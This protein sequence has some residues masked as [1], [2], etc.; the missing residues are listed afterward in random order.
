MFN[1]GSYG[2]RT[3]YEQDSAEVIGNNCYVPTSGYCLV[4]YV[5]YLTGEDCK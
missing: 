3:D 4:E 1:K 2:K 5:Q